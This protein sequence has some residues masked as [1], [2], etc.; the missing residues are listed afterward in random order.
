L[1]AISLLHASGVPETQNNKKLVY[2]PGV[3]LNNDYYKMGEEI[4]LSS[5]AA[6]VLSQYLET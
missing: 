3:V 6:V 4:L 5:L 1:K 2:E